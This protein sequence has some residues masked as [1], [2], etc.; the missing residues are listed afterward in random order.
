MRITTRGG[1]LCVARKTFI[2]RVGFPTVEERAPTTNVP[3][4][5]V[6]WRKLGVHDFPGTGLEK[7]ADLSTRYKFVKAVIRYVPATSANVSGQIGI[8][9]DL[10]PAF[11]FP[12]GDV[13]SRLVTLRAKKN[14]TWGNV[15]DT[16]SCALPQSGKVD[17]YNEPN[18]Q[19]LKVN[20]QATFFVM[21][22]VEVRNTLDGSLWN[23]NFGSLE[24]DWEVEYKIPRVVLKRGDGPKTNIAIMGTSNAGAWSPGTYL[25]DFGTGSAPNTQVCGVIVRT[26][27]DRIFGL[28][29]GEQY[30]MSRVPTDPAFPS[31][32][33]DWML[34]QTLLGAQRRDFTDMVQWSSEAQGEIVEI[35]W[36]AYGPE[37]GEYN[38]T[39]AEQ[40]TMQVLSVADSM[41][42]IDAVVRTRDPRF[43]SAQYYCQILGLNEEGES[44]KDL[45]AFVAMTGDG[46]TFRTIPFTENLAMITASGDQIKQASGWSDEDFLLFL[47]REFRSAALFTLLITNLGTIIRFG[48][49]FLRAIRVGI[50]I[51]RAFQDNGFL[52]KVKWNDDFHEN[53]RRGLHTQLQVMMLPST[54]TSAQEKGVDNITLATRIL[55]VADET[56]V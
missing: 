51:K 4:A 12:P 53:K 34:F 36:L 9:F 13:D 22:F 5:I 47:G 49:M 11:K 39:N 45:N 42:E 14:A 30:Y 27:S 17:Y 50:A 54:A 2:G 19:D 43:Q 28:A 35:Q 33:Q 23:G 52:K 3:G 7:F 48:S 32:K 10:D 38:D 18:S 37:T 31:G 24:L 21:I 46:P 20:I 1:N 15:Y 29:T 41:G 6:A 25:L 26:Y 44:G 8:G 40:T 16:L 55:S 56:F